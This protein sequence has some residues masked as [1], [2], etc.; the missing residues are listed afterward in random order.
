MKKIGDGM[1][2]AGSFLIFL[3]WA[4]SL[5]AQETPR[6]E[7]TVSESQVFEG[8]RITLKIEVAGNSSGNISR[9]DMPPIDGFRYLSAFPS[10]S[11]SYSMVNGV[12]SM[13]YSFTW[14]LEATRRG[15]HQI[16]PLS[17]TFEGETY[18]TRPV[19]ITVLDSGSRPGRE[20]IAQ[21]PD[22]F[23][24]MQVSDQH[25]VRGQQVIAEL[26]IYF[27]SDMDLSSYQVSQG[28]VTEG[29]WQED[30][31]EYHSARAENVILDGVRYR[32]AVLRK[33]ALFPTRRGEL[34]LQPYKIQANVRY[35]TRGGN[36]Y[37]FFSGFRSSTRNLAL[38]SEEVVID[39]QDLPAAPSGLFINAVGRLN[40][41]RSLSDQRIKLGES[42]EIIT[43]VSGSGNIALVSRPEYSIPAEFDVYR[44][45]EV[46]EL[47][48]RSGRVSGKKTFRDVIIARKVGRF[49]IP[50]SR[51]A[52][53]NDDRRRYET[54]T[55][56]ALSFEVVRDPNAQIG[57]VSDG[58][59]NV[60]P[61]TGIVRWVTGQQ[62]PAYTTWWF[63]A[64][65]MFPVIVL[66]G[67]YRVKVHRDKLLFDELFYRKQHALNKSNESLKAA[68]ETTSPH[69]LKTPYTYI[70]QALADFI[71]DRL[72]LPPSGHSDE[73]L[74]D[75]LRGNNI[76]DDLAG[77]V[78][79][80]LVKCSTI[81]FAPVSKTENVI[82]DIRSG[83]KLVES[84]SKSL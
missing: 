9:P 35:N 19:T 83:A 25:P 32:R 18:E 29:F 20:D 13:S 3:L 39:V 49:E 57:F 28:W 33:H 54:V 47:D 82:A 61:V 12:S 51:V 30:L 26:V 56:P 80:L 50:Q 60:T 41:E 31:N 4:G 38:E 22:V 67:A 70:H 34:K 46:T 17:V 76:P 58:R 69:D 59:F 53:Y 23:L 37:D 73:E 5:I 74:V 8:E 2:A 7:A 68:R 63:W 10:T 65:L 77:N 52:M 14:Q 71:T 42:V 16:P 64:G 21:R 62:K 81:R 11:T 24:E 55:L 48:K 79:A 66:A 84:L 15:V 44:P 1:K 6:V 40:V 75:F 78:K 72:G 43:E 45:Q 36:A 27:K